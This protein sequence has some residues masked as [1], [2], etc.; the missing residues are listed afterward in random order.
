MREHIA[1]CQPKRVESRR[2]SITPNEDYLSLG[3]GLSAAHRSG[4]C[5]CYLSTSHGILSGLDAVWN[6]NYIAI[7]NLLRTASKYDPKTTHFLVFGMLFIVIALVEIYSVTIS[8][9]FINLET[10]DLLC[11]SSTTNWLNL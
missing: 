4:D 1:F 3:R 11:I 10:E 8:G 6:A 9:T 7:K 5:I 2:V